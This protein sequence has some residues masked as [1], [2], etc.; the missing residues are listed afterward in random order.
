MKAPARD[1]NEG[2]I[3]GELRALGHLV[4]PLSQGGGVPDLLVLVDGVGPLVLLEV[5]D[6][7]KQ[8]C[9]QHLTTAQEHWHRRWKCAVLFVVKSIDEAVA[10]VEGS[11]K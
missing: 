2:L 6:G 8:A 7:G 4:Q 3:I 10:A 11:R 1:A 5:K 9:R